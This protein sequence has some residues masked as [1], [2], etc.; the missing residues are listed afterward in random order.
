MGQNRDYYYYGQFVALSLLQG[1]SGP[2]CLGPG[3]TDYILHK[4]L[5]K[6][7]PT[8]D[9]IPD[10]IVRQA[11]ID[12]LKI[13]DSQEFCDEAS[14][15]F[16]PRFEAGYCKPIVTRVDGEEMSQCISLHHTILLCRAELDQFLEG[17]AV[18]GVLDILRQHPNQ[19]RKVFENA[20]D[21]LTAE[22]VDN[23]FNIEYS[24]RGNAKREKEEAICFNFTNF[25]EEVESGKVGGEGAPMMLGDV[26]AFITGATNIPVI[27]FEFQPTMRF[28]HD[29]PKG[30][31]LSSNTC[32]NIITFPVNDCLIEYKS[33]REELI[34]CLRNTQGFGCL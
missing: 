24:P 20:H 6:I 25:L 10:N 26:L 23:L 16:S 13:N 28:N 12:L 32:S 14:F 18:N 1:C 15:N 3:V 21:P 17:L 33:F 22:I 29:A 5:A 30:W 11:L 2:K 27:G 4:D 7:K 19:S 34:F 8:V 9:E 31:K